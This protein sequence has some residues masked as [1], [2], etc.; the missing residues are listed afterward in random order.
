M[1]VMIETKNECVR[2]DEKEKRKNLKGLEWREENG[3]DDSEEK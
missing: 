3:N 1:I 2:L